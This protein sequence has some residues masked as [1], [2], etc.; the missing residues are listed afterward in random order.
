MAK[1]TPDA[2][3]GTYFLFYFFYFPFYMLIVTI[4]ISMFLVNYVPAL[5]PFELGDSQFFVSLAFK[6]S[7]DVALRTFVHFLVIEI[8]NDQTVRTSSFIMIVLWRYLT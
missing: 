4:L 7:F 3:T 2:I 5:I 8:A 6:R 1:A